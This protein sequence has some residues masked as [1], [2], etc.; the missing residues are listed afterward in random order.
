MC[1]NRRGC[2]LFGFLLFMNFVGFF[3]C[4]FIGWWLIDWSYDVL[5]TRM[6]TDENFFK[7]M[8]GFADEQAQENVGNS[9]YDVLT[10]IQYSMMVVGSVVIAFGVIAFFWNAFDIWMLLVPWLNRNTGK[11]LL[12]CYHD[13][14]RRQLPN[15]E[16][17]DPNLPIE[18]CHPT[19][20]N[21]SKGY[22]KNN[23]AAIAQI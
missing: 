23:E 4:I 15:M 5:K 7:G 17:V 18:D 20:K 14:I 16:P 11:P 22:N 13:N 1:L 8:S 9:Y 6:L 12:G 21:T 3:A 10:M 19:A 2:P